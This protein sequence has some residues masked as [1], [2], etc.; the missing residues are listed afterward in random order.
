M[1]GD[2]G[3][4]RLA[5][6]FSCLLSLVQDWVTN[7]IRPFYHKLK[8]D[9][10]LLEKVAISISQ[11][12]DSNADLAAALIPLG[13]QKADGTALASDKMSRIKRVVRHLNAPPNGLG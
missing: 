12:P 10:D 11:H 5:I 1:S 8:D 6:A 9:P 4:G 7:E 3:F 2:L 13:F